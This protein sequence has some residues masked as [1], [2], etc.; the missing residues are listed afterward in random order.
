MLCVL[1]HLVAQTP[2]Q[3]RILYRWDRLACPNVL[4][5]SPRGKVLG[6]TPGHVLAA[7]DDDDV[8]PSLRPEVAEL[9]KEQGGAQL[10]AGDAV[11]VVVAAGTAA[12]ERVADS[13]ARVVFEDKCCCPLC[14][15]GRV[16]ACV[17]GRRLPERRVNDFVVIE[18]LSGRVLACFVGLFSWVPSV[19]EAR[20]V[21]KC[22][23][24]AQGLASGG[25]HGMQVLG[26]DDETLHCTVLLW[27]SDAGHDVER[28]RSGLRRVEDGRGPHTEGT[29]AHGG[30]DVVVLHG[31]RTTLKGATRIEIAHRFRVPRVDQQTRYQ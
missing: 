18:L 9:E 2:P 20:T 22:D 30:H 13:T 1:A 10:C 11:P 27:H 15:N 29:I 7:G 16:D 24:T 28:H 14:F 4:P 12:L 17:V 19:D 5:G 25:I 26:T 31:Q 8:T 3:I 23:H 6:C 21:D